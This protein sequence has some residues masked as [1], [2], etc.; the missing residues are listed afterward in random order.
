ML[1]LGCFI[2]YNTIIIVMPYGQSKVSDQIIPKSND[3]ID[4]NLNLVAYALKCTT[5]VL[6]A[7]K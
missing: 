2:E 1:Y 5:N 3:S 7:Q 6:L 4:S